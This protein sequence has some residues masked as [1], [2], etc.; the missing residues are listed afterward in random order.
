MLAATDVETLARTA[1]ILAVAFTTAAAVCLVS[2][3]GGERS[4]AEKLHRFQTSN[5]TYFG[6]FSLVELYATG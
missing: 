2:L 6:M 5:S 4:N 1:L 3:H